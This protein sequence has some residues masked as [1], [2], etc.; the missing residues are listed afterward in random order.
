MPPL[1]GFINISKHSQKMCSVLFQLSY[2]CIVSLLAM[3]A[4]PCNAPTSFFFVGLSIIAI[5]CFILVIIEATYIVYWFSEC[6]FFVGLSV[7]ACC[8]FTRDS[9]CT[10]AFH[11]FKASFDAIVSICIPCLL[12]NVCSL[13][14]RMF[15]YL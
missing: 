5:V 15:S 12:F 11:R 1:N 8:F 13:Q 2:F 14:L 3:L 4:R 6:F 9:T 7:V 10:S